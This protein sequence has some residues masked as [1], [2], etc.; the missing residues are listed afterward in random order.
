MKVL[1]C[2]S[3]KWNLAFNQI[4][5]WLHCSLRNVQRRQLNAGM[6]QNA[7]EFL[8][9]PPAHG[10]WQYSL[11]HQSVSLSICNVLPF[12]SLDLK[13]SFFVGR[14]VVQIF[15]SSL[16]IKVTGSRSRSQSK[17]VYVCPIRERSVFD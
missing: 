3:L 11:S 10:A 6:L 16:Y 1:S 8:F 2:M 5:S 12:E 14:Y 7:Y 9:L 4:L 13:S 17:R 15:R